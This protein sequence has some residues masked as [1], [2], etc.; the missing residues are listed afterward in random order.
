MSELG[1]LLEAMY[2]AHTRF[3]TFAG[4]LDERLIGDLQSDDSWDW[5][6]EI[7]PPIR[8]V[9]TT[10]RVLVAPPRARITRLKSPGAESVAVVLDGRRRFFD[11]P[12]WGADIGDQRADDLPEALGAA[13]HLL[14]PGSMLA[15]LDIKSHERGVHAGREVWRVTATPRWPLAWP[16]GGVE[17]HELSVDRE[18]GVVLR[19]AGLVNYEEVRLH[20]F[21][22]V[23]FD[24]AV[25]I[26]DFA[27]PE[28]ALDT[29]GLEPAEAAAR[30]PFA[31]F[32][33]PLPVGNITYR[34][35]RGRF[36]PESTTIEYEGILLVET[37]AVGHWTI[38]GAY[39]QVAVNG[40]TAIVQDGQI[41]LTIGGTTIELQAPGADAARLVELAA[42]LI[43]LPGAVD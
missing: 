5:E 16:I 8:D 39:E 31:L 38:L 28:A 36:Q 17:Q 23:A 1:D 21:R 3:A 42:S 19:R 11:S 32:G 41:R 9:A 4:V 26:E 25:T 37:L 10:T 43:P 14:A 27:F 22:E 12:G 20:E 6:G 29:G 33:L 13:R 15:A 34:P 35:H 7:H 18:R 30:S 2:T 40:S 24:V